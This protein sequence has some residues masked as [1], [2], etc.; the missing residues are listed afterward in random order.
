MLLT[1][2]HVFVPILHIVCTAC[3]FTPRSANKGRCPTKTVEDCEAAT[4]TGSDMESSPNQQRTVQEAPAT[5]AC[6]SPQMDTGSRSHGAKWPI[7]LKE[8]RRLM[9]YI[10]KIHT[11]LTCED[12]MQRLKKNDGIPTEELKITQT[13]S[14]TKFRGR[15]RF[16]LCEGPHSACS[17]MERECKSGSLQWKISPTPHLTQIHFWGEMHT[18]DRGKTDR[19][20]H[21]LHLLCK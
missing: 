9:W 20:P 6:N 16:M 10:R 2:F 14:N 7:Q 4:A 21:C 15:W 19:S 8:D 18:I 5:A 1:L 12:V 13:L 3:T 17:G 11:N